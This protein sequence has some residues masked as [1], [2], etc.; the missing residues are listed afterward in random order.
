MEKRIAKNVKIMDFGVPKPF[1][2]QQ[3]MC[4]FLCFFG[5]A[6]FIEFGNE[7]YDVRTWKL[8]V[9][10]RKNSGFCKIGNSSK[11]EKS[12]KKSIEKPLQNE[13]RTMKKSR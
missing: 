10:L 13:V 7:F 6:F 2:N 8:V 11:A 9:L 5:T 3:K 1:R 4:F 12:I